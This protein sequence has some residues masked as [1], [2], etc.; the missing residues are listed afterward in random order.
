MIPLIAVLAKIVQSKEAAPRRTAVG[1][2]LYLAA[3]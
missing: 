1:R 3:A 2:P